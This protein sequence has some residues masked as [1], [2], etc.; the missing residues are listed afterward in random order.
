[1]KTWIK[2]DPA[3][4]FDK[5]IYHCINLRQTYRSCVYSES[6]HHQRGTTCVY[7]MYLRNNCCKI[8]NLQKQ[9]TRCSAWQREEGDLFFHHIQ[10]SSLIYMQPLLCNSWVFV[11]WCFNPCLQQAYSLNLL[12]LFDPYHML[13]IKTGIQ[14]FL[15]C[16][17]HLL[18]SYMSYMYFYLCFHMKKILQVFTHKKYQTLLWHEI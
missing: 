11:I 5:I 7:S 10:F 9:D 15:G 16:Q 14:K 1:M 12:C 3:K 4:L 17:C 6:A 18:R 13:N 2:P 8:F